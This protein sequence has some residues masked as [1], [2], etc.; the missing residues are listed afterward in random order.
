M[1]HLRCSKTNDNRIP[2]IDETPPGLKKIEM[3]HI[4]FARYGAHKHSVY[5]SAGRCPALKYYAPNGAGG[6]IND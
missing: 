3:N 1:E 2:S 5:Q 4:Y 6:A